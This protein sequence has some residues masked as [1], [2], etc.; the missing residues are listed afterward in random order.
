MVPLYFYTH[1]H[2]FTQS[3]FFPALFTQRVVVKL[4]MFIRL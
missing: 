2:S 4:I 1:S 3:S